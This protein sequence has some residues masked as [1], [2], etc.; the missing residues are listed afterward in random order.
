LFLSAAVDG[1]I[2]ARQHVSSHARADT[3]TSGSV[4]MAVVNI[5]QVNMTMHY[6]LMP[7][8]MRMRLSWWIGR[9]MVV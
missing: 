5:R 3:D 8:P 6:W 2:D 9:Q 7:V 1:K 4:V